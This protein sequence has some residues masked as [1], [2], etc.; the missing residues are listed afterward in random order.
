MPVFGRIKV[1][2]AAALT[3]MPR[4]APLSESSP[5]GISTEILGDLKEFN[6]AIMFLAGPF[7]SL[8]R[9]VPKI[10]STIRSLFL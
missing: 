8:S 6:L 5:D 10:A 3:A 7:I 4:G 2:V 1:T 9:P